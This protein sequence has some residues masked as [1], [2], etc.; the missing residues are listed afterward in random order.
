MPLLGGTLVAC[1]NDEAPPMIEQIRLA[2]TFDNGATQP[3]A[4][5]PVR[6]VFAFGSHPMAPPSEVHPVTQAIASRNRLRLIVNKLLL[7]NRLEEIGCRFTVDDDVFARIPIGTTPDDIARCAV[8]QPEL[9]ASCPGH[10]DHPQCVCMRPEGCP[11]GAAP[12][13]TPIVTPRGESVGV[14]DRDLDGAADIMRLI[15]GLAQLTCGAFA[16][17]ID[18]DTSFWSPGGS[19]DR[20]PGDTFDELGPALVL[21]PEVA[22]PTLQTCTLAL[23][24]AVTDEA[25]TRL[26]APPGGELARGCTPG[27]TS[28]FAFTVEPQSYRPSPA[29]MKT[30]Q[31]RTDMIAIAAAAPVAPASLANITVTQGAA[32]PF[33]SFTPT[34]LATNQIGLRWDVELAASTT[35][36][37][38]IPSTVTDLYGIGA[39]AAFS[40]SFTTA[41]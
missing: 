33:T 11:S 30:G 13:G 24:P 31:S 18:P 26:C 4:T 38:T 39:P 16:V 8:A 20:P 25:G 34:L 1:S 40:F 32:T 23:S 9:A 37:V 41:P 27:D 14:A 10:G 3:Q 17:A 5:E 29:I 22:L 6:N 28:A 2:E 36:T 21:T 15:P 7:G 35:Y 19:Q 12:D